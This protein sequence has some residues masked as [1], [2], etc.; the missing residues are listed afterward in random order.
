MLQRTLKGCFVAVLGAAIRSFAA[1]LV[2]TG[3]LQTTASALSVFALS[4]L[5]GFFCSPL[6]S[7][8]LLFTLLSSTLLLREAHQNIFRDLQD[9]KNPGI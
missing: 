5:R 6:P 9:L 3:T 2:A 1:L 7:C 8:P 4:S